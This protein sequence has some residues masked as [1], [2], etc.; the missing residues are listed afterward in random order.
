VSAKPILMIW[1]IGPQAEVSLSWSTN[2]N[3]NRRPLHEVDVAYS[4]PL[5]ITLF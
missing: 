4:K 1:S 5:L 3:S 2:T